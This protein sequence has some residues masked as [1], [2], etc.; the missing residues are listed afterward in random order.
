M[1]A[2]RKFAAVEG[3]LPK[4]WTAIQNSGRV[5]VTSENAYAGLHSVRVEVAAE[6]KACGIGQ[7][8]EN[9]AIRQDAAY[10]FR[11]WLKTS[12]NRTI[13]VRLRDA[14]G[15]RVH[16]E[17]QWL[18]RKGGWQLLS[19][20][21]VAANAADSNR[22]E[23]VSGTPGLFWIGAVSLQPADS[24]H[25]MRR[26]V[27][28]LL[29]AV[30]PARLRYPGGCYAEFYRWR[31]GLLPVDQRP[32][33]GPT[34]LDFALPDTDDYDSHE[35]GIDEFM[36]L[37]REIGAEPSIT[38]RV[39]ENTPEDAAAW[40]EYCNGGPE[41][42]WGKV[43][44][45][46]GHRE[47]YG[48][49]YWFVGNELYYFGRG[50]AN[51][52]EICARQSRLFAEAM[53]KA[54]PS[55]H[56]IGCTDLADEKDWNRPLF[57]EA[58]QLLELCSAHDYLFDHFKGG[59]LERF[60]ND[61]AGIALAPTRRLQPRL[62]SYRAR[63]DRETPAGK[64]YGITFDEWNTLWKSPG[65]VSMAL[66]AAGVLNMLC[67]ESG[68]LGIE[69][70]YYFMPINEGVIGVTPQ[71]ARLLP[72]G[73]VFRL[74]KVHQGNR[75]LKIPPS[76]PD[77]DLTAS[78]APDGKRAYVTLINR[79]VSAGHQIELEAAQATQA[80]VT[81]LVP[82]RLDANAPEFT[83][84]RAKLPIA[85]NGRIRLRMSPASVARVEIVR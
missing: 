85:A 22:L 27:V 74:F 42:K 21:F 11:L 44:A 61:L 34:G 23:I 3:T 2:N 67:R 12:R 49:K 10:N 29:K 84:T 80:S 76:N 66:Y 60:R 73:Q 68:P 15:N 8:Q 43:R 65:T 54:D 57:A 75:L 9:L 13:A 19:A 48:V 83:E 16:F 51:R 40:M 28:E 45:G 50:G 37:C 36:A 20:R 82:S 58:G 31:D 63:L 30:K 53:K 77:I 14:R 1:V 59:D 52:A 38:A 4:R 39:S 26:D 47:P 18:A 70:A 72:P 62:A 6:G 25:G 33:I 78:L 69:Q 7:A 24:F 46:R 5:A 81:F 35:I 55:V 64:H 17:K 41:T 79:S 56:L 32:P 71:G